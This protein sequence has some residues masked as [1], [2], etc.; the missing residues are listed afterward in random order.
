MVKNRMGILSPAIHG[1]S[2]GPAL[3]VHQDLAV[4]PPPPDFPRRKVS[5]HRR[6]GRPFLEQVQSGNG[7]PTKTCGIPRAYQ[8]PLCTSRIIQAN[9]DSEFVWHDRVHEQANIYV[10]QF[11]EVLCIVHN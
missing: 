10:H 8:W 5:S 9:S 11:L 6:W 7:I 1:R 4:N 3:D 2:L